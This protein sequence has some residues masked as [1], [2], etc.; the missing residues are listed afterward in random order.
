MMHH[1]HTFLL[2]ALVAAQVAVIEHADEDIQATGAK[3]ALLKHLT[4]ATKL[5]KK[6][7]G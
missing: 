5:A 6:L 4:E 3:A 7:E 1:E 2:R